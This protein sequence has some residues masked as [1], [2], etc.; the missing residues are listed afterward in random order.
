[1]AETTSASQRHLRD[2]LGKIGLKRVKKT[3]LKYY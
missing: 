2:F 3:C 1:M